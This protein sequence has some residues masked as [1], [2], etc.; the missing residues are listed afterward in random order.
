MNPAYVLLVLFLPPADG[1][2]MGWT[3]AFPSMADCRRAQVDANRRIT[4]EG[5][6]LVMITCTE[7]RR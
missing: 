5:N 6:A 3:Q 7:E 4:R 2:I 1:L